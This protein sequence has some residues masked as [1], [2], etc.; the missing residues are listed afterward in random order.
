MN[1]RE[2]WAGLLAEA[3][4]D[5]ETQPQHICELCVELLGVS[6]AGISLVTTSGNHGVVCATDDVSA[7]IEDLQLTLGEGP[8]VDAVS[9]G[10]PVLV[11]DLLKP[12]DIVIERWPAFLHGADAAGVRAVFALP[13]RIGAIGVGALDLYR[14]RPGDLDDA[15]LPGALMAADAAAYAL[16]HLDSG[17]DDDFRD[18]SDTRSSYQM[19]VH[20]ATGMVQVQMGISTEEA[21]LMLRARAYATGRPLAD[22]ATDVVTRR[23]RFSPE[24]T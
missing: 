20:Q 24:D 1:D 9:S 19:Q 16:L 14:D 22:V 21:L 13:L 10:A 15:G 11:P 7:Q 3:A 18:D 12:D 5:R 23:L 8:C 2:R 6:G 17:R 4:K